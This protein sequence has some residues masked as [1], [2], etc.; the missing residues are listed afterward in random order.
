MK[1]VDRKTVVH[2]LGDTRTVQHFNTLLGDKPH[3]LGLVATMYPDLAISTLTD[4]LRNVYYNPKSSSSNFQPINSMAVQWDIDVNYIHK[5]AIKRDVNDAQ[6]GLN[7]VPFTIVLEQKYYDKNDTFTLENKQQLL[8]IAP[9]RMLTDNKSWEH[10]VILVGND[11]AK[12][13]DP[14]FLTKGRV[15]RFRSNYFPELSER[16]YTKYTSN[17]E[18]HRN[19]MSRHRASESV[20]ADFKMKEKVYLELAKK[21]GKEY[22]KLHRHEKDCMDTFMHARNNNQIFGQTNFDENGKCLDQDEQ[23][24]D[25]PMGDGVIAQIERYCDKFL[26]SQL[27]SAVLDDVL[28]SMVEKSDRPTG[29]SYVVICNERLYQQFGRIMK[30]DYRFTNPSDKTFFYSKE[31]GKVK[32]GAEFNSYTVQGNTITFLPDRALSQEYDQYGYGIFLDTTA[33]LKSGR[34]NIATFTMEGSEMVEGRVNGLGGQDGKT[35]G[36]VSTG[37]HGSEYHLI[38]YSC[39]AVFN[40]YKSFILKEN[41]IIL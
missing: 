37:V 32:T 17:T 38:G 19:Y 20:S 12:Y 21:D 23:G 4:A 25:I 11:Y 5:V 13:V 31:G 22:F 35:S 3:K 2:N 1:V 34:P 14:R 26:Y 41:V 10:T 15:T 9:P 8:V 7:K 33:D 18:V 27:S 28:Y 30:D 24:R 36:V 6:P 40:P 39:A 16:G 29:N